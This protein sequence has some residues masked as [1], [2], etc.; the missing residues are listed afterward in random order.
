MDKQRILDFAAN[1]TDKIFL[2]KSFDKAVSCQK[3]K[4]RQYI[5]FLSPHE[6]ALLKKAARFFDADIGFFGGYESSERKMAAF[7]PLAPEYDGR[8]SALE[9]DFADFP[10]TAVYIR[11]KPLSAK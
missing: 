6:Q 9:P 7:A 5:V 11:K 4:C 10:I 8:D 2:S 3:Y 1:E